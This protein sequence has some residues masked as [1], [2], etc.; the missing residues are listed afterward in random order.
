MTDK[1]RFKL[2]VAIVS[3]GRCSPLVEAAKA[4]G[5]EGATI[6]RGRG[7]GVHEGAKF[8]GLPIE[9]EKDVML[10]LVPVDAAEVVLDAMV[11]AGQ[12]DQPGKG[13][14]FMLDVPRVAGIVH[15][16]EVLHKAGE[17]A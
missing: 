1:I 7:T 17:E 12:L 6:V 4:A 11:T 14:V 16:G 10:V 13:I 2:L 15:R 5:A 9:P 3:Q 8:L